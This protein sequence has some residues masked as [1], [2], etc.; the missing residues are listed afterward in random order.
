MKENHTFH[1]ASSSLHLASWKL[2]HSQFFASSKNSLF[3]PLPGL[4]LCWVVL[5]FRGSVLG[6]TLQ[7]PSVVL[8]KPGK[9]LNYVSC[10]LDTTEA[11]LLLKVA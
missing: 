11:H 2:W 5:V 9:D 10:H 4:E 8:V 1:F 7:S 6:K 3:Q